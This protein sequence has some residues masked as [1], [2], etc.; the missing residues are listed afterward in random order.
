ML[1]QNIDIASHQH[2]FLMAEDNPADEEIVREMLS[3]A[4]GDEYSIV[5]VDKFS[6]IAEALTENKFEVL[7]LDMGLP[8]QSGINNVKEIGDKYPDLPIVVLTGQDDLSL[9]AG[10]LQLGAQ[11]YLSK[12][13]I[14]PEVLSRSLYY[15]Q[16]RKQIEKRLK[17]ALEDSAFRNTQL[18]AQ[19]KHDNLTGLPNRNYIHEA[20][21]RILFRAKRN[22]QK[23]ALIFF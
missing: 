5:C 2:I 18:E 3:Q 1:A 6:K 20:G 8:D 17:A 16:E 23:L 21:E 22:K 11:D 15:A 9:A 12:N 19:T 7:I 13:H 14:T 10:A 4:F